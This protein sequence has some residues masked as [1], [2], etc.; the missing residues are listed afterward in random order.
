MS[1]KFVLNKMKANFWIL[2]ALYGICFFILA[3]LTMQLDRFVTTESGLMNWLPAVLFTDKELAQ[4]ILS[5]IS[6]SLLTMTTITF[7]SVLVVETTFLA[8]YSP[9]TLQ[10]F[11]AESK[12][13]HGLGTFIGGYVYALILLIQVRENEPG[14]VFIIPSF[15]IM[16]TFVCLGMFVFLIHH[17]TE[18]IKVGNLISYITKETLYSVDKHKSKMGA[19]PC[20]SSKYSDLQ[21][22]SKKA[23]EVRSKD[24]GYIQYIELEK[25]IDFSVENNL[26]IKFEKIPGDYVDVDTPL[27]SVWNS[28]ESFNQHLLDFIFLT[29]DQ[30]SIEDVQLGIQKLAEIALRAIAPGKNDPETAINCIQQLGQILT[31]IANIEPENP[32]YCDEDGNLRV[33]LEQPSFSDYL[34]GSFY[35][36]RHYGRADVSVMVSILKALSLVAETNGQKIKNTVWEFSTYIME[37]LKAE[38]W[39][40]LDKKLLNTHWQ[41]LSKACNKEDEANSMLL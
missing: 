25:L 15:A 26:I 23:N 5:A 2:P 11:N 35:Q 13:Q 19:S 33:I 41:G 37:G 34:Y 29:P 27:V 17:V 8:Q 32:Y 30:E 40:S 1:L 38:Q 20:T 4:T 9:R 21:L 39:L 14:N 31:K 18:W 12:I 24:Q 22:E 6:T 16:V 7:S 36:I 10:N 28:N 3:I